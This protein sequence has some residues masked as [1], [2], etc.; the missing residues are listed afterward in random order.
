MVLRL[1][2]EGML[3]ILAHLGQTL[4]KQLLAVRDPLRHLCDMIGRLV[5]D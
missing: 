2:V 5:D 1:E 4:R 3:V